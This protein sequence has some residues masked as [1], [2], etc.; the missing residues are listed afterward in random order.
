[1]LYIVP[2]VPTV[3]I[4]QPSRASFCLSLFAPPPRAIVRQVNP[5]KAV[6][7]PSLRYLLLLRII[8]ITS[9]GSVEVVFFLVQ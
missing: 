6:I 3:P 7:G 5:F 1:M 9:I 8:A 2:I 4:P